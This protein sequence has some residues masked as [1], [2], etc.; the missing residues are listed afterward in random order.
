LPETSSPPPIF[1][2]FCPVCG[3][4]FRETRSVERNLQRFFVYAEKV[5]LCIDKQSGMN[6]RFTYSIPPHA[7][8][9]PATASHICVSEPRPTSLNHPVQPLKGLRDPR[10]ASVSYRAF[11]PVGAGTGHRV[12]A[13]TS[14]RGNQKEDLFKLLVK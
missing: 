1:S 2:L 14:D 11:A 7:L 6:Q 5:Y 3:T 8:S 4:S 12:C 10:A 9:F 13:G